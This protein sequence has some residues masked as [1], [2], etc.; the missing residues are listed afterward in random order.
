MMFK[1][2]YRH[3]ICAETS[4]VA[5]VFP[6]LVKNNTNLVKHLQKSSEILRGFSLEHTFALHIV[7]LRLAIG[8]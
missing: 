1:Q 3:V 5:V 2:H 6:R 7:G 4:S 8:S